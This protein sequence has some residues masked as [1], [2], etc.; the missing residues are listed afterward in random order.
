MCLG[1]DVRF[2]PHAQSSTCSSWKELSRGRREADAEEIELWGHGACIHHV[3]AWDEQR[4]GNPRADLG[5]EE[6]ILETTG[7]VV[8][9]K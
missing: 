3:T 9:A 2:L 1:W 7:R 5:T 8:Q 6:A 4:A